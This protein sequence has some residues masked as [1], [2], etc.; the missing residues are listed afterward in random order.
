[1]KRKNQKLKKKNNYWKLIKKMLK[2]KMNK[3]NNYKNKSMKLMIK[4]KKKKN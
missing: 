4:L 1:M 2:H 3:I